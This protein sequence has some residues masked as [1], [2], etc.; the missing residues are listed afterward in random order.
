MN[1]HSPGAMGEFP[2]NAFRKKML[3]KLTGLVYWYIRAKNGT[4]SQKK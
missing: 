1:R 2:A 4:V 3:D